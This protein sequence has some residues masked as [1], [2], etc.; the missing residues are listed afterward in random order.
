MTGSFVWAHNSWVVGTVHWHSN[1]SCHMSQTWPCVLVVPWVVCNDTIVS[2]AS[3]SPHSHC[4]MPT[5]WN[6]N[7]L[8]LPLMPLTPPR[9]ID[10]TIKT[11]CACG[12][13]FEG[14]H[15]WRGYGPHDYIWVMKASVNQAHARLQQQVGACMKK[16]KNQLH[17]GA[18]FELFLYY[19]YK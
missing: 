19:L 17:L 4:L 16:C 11:D 2:T 18:H 10:I 6:P 9:P 3:R 1:H 8:Y 14:R 12:A 15:K 13:D 7:S 5:P